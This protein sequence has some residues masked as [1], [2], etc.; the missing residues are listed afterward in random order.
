VTKFLAILAVALPLAACVA[1]SQGLLDQHR[2]DCRAGNQFSCKIIP[3]LEIQV[4]HEKE[5]QAANVANGIA[6]GLGALAVG[7]AA[8]YAASHPVY[9]PV[10]VV[11]RPWWAC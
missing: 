10:Y 5:V 1:P 4:A 7:A 11:C 6:L 8:G 9:Q 3:G 2:T